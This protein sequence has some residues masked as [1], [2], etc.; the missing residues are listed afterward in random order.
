MR[1]RSDD[2]NTLADIPWGRIK[3]WERYGVD[4]IEAALNGRVRAA[5]GRRELR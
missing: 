4:E 5:N 3:N 2:D 1:H